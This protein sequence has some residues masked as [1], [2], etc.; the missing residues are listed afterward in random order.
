M[1][2]LLRTLPS[3]ESQEVLRR[4]R[5]GI[6][7]TTVLNQVRAGDLLLQLAVSPETRFRYWFPYRS[8]MLK[9]L[10]LSNPYMSSMIYEGASPF[11]P[12]QFSEALEHTHS[13][14]LTRLESAEYR[15]L[16]L[17]PFHAAQVVEPRLSDAKPSLWTGVCDDDALMRDSLRVFFR[18]EYQFTAVF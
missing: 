12:T 1:I 18:C 10:T 3:Q 15:D 16:Y 4:L 11:S 6:D 14:P 17:K 5:H 2:E 7:I 9:E 8:E 13:T